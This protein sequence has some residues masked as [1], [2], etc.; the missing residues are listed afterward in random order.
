MSYEIRCTVCGQEAQSL[1]DYKCGKCGSPLDVKLNI[2]FNIRGIQTGIYGIW[3]Y[4]KFFPYVKTSEIVTLGE[5]WTPLVKFSKNLYFKL[6][7]LNPTGSF[8]DRG[9]TVL[10]SA[11]HKQIKACSGYIAEDSSGNA[12]ASIAAYAARAGLKAKIYVPENVSGPKFNQIIFYGAEAVKVAGSRSHVA[13]EAQKPEA[14]KFYVGHILHPLFRDGIRSL[15]YEIAEQL[16]WEPPERVYLP[17]SAGTLLLG[18]ISGF[19]HLKEAGVIKDLPKIVA[20]QTRQVSPL[21]HRFKGFPYQPPERIDSVADALVSTNPP[22]L[23][24]MV[25]SL[26]EVNGDAV[27]VEEEEIHQAF[28]ELAKMGFFVEPSSAVAYAAYKKQLDK[29]EITRE[30][31]TVVILTGS[32]L[33]TVLKPN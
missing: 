23:E 7:N 13:D 17:V 25:K 9:S 29:G 8:K 12:G 6:E 4:T 27:M 24:L 16:G 5:G 22:L 26:R 32:G 10:I 21:C 18:V 11:V 2:A 15:A 19:K 1:M 31:R 30:E 33:K 20:C 14:G 3:R 28:K